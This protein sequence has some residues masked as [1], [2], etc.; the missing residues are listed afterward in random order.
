[1]RDPTAKY[2]FAW[3][4]GNH[5]ELL[6][7]GRQ[8]FPAMLAAI[9]QAQSQVW[10]EMYLVESG[11]VADH[12][13]VALCHAA[14]RGLD[15]RVLVDDYGASGLQQVDRQRLQQAG[16]QLALYNPLHWR[17]WLRNLLR[18]HRKLLI[19]D[20][21]IGYVGGA[22]LSDDFD[23]PRRP[24][25]SWREHMLSIEGAVLA[26]WQALFMQVWRE[27]HRSPIEAL[28]AA[29]DAT[30]VTGGVNGRV[31]PAVALRVQDIR[32]SLYYRL[33]GA[34]RRIWLMTAYFVPSRRTLR[35]LRQAAQRGVD[36][37]LL[38]PG[39]VSD[40]PAIAHAGRRF[41]S[42]LLRAGVRVFEYQPRFMHAKAVICDGWVSIGSSNFDRWNLHWNLEANQEI[43]DQPFADRLC[44]VI[45]SDLHDCIEIRYPDWHQRGLRARL[46]EHLWGRIDRLL[47]GLGRLRRDR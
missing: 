24:Q 38:L 6:V 42:P 43:D 5:F 26:D 40:H 7:D 4:P 33:Q 39:P 44:A 34:E 8:F 35:A 41:Y 45:V 13:I 28:G 14:R 30:A 16:V 22:G 31:A 17:K 10:L 37:R 9:E 19:V 47:E 20:G 25:R 12:F 15:V 2:R 27:Q 21:R 23:H 46:R 11:V 1:M 29:I 32:R 18:D 3:R 36:V